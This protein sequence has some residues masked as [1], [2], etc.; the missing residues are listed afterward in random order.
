MRILVGLIEHLGDIAACEPVAR[1]LR[2]RHPDAQLD[3]AVATPYRDLIDSNPHVDRSLIVGCLG[4]WSA[5]AASGAHDAVFDLHVEEK[6]CQPCG[7]VLTRAG[8]DPGI[9]PRT[10]FHHG[11]LLEAFSQGAGLPRLSVPPRLYLGTAEVAAADA[12]GLPRHFCVLHRVSNLA[13]KD[14]DDARWSEIARVAREE[15]GLEVVE[16]GAGDAARLPPPLPASISLVN[17]LPVLVTA[18]VIRRAAVFLGVDSGPAHLA[19]AQ[20]VPGVILLGQQPPFD[21]HLPY[22]GF[23]A[24]G[25]PGIR[26]VRNATGPVRDIPAAPVA[27]ALRAVAALCHLPRPSPAPMPCPAEFQARRPASPEA[28]VIAAS[29]LFDAAWYALHHP[30]ALAEGLHPADHYLRHGASAGHDPGP[31]FSSSWYVE[32]YADVARAGA[33]PLLHYIRS[34]M[35]EGRQR[36]PAHPRREPMGQELLEQRRITAALQ[37]QLLALEEELERRRRG[38]ARALVERLCGTPA[39]PLAEPLRRLGRGLRRAPG[40]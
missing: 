10:Y 30:E 9:N 33:N 39:W 36:R 37:G 18:E 6:P 8:G 3:W 31:W 32:T 22:T 14:W 16:V 1:Y 40:G 13:A 7:F 4:E 20:G 15:L 34:G 5:L 2:L 11:A 26:L 27:A 12:L 38:W 17:R 23:Y 21:G 25:G 35:G 28:E 29:V 19:N 24:S